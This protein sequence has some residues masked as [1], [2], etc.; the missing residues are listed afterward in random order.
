MVPLIPGTLIIFISLVSPREGV[1]CSFHSNFGYMMAG[2]NF[3]PMLKPTGVV[4]QGAYDPMAFFP[5]CASMFIFSGRSKERQYWI[6][7]FRFQR[8]L[9]LHFLNRQGLVSY[10]TALEILRR[11]VPLLY[12]PPKACLIYYLYW[13]YGISL[14]PS[15][16]QSN[17]SHDVQFRI[18]IISASKYPRAY[19]SHSSD[20]S[21]C[22]PETGGILHRPPQGV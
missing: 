11:R 2:E 20:M 16:V 3:I 15:I 22:R 18:H 4:D 13:R 17:Y 5:V 12:T 6:H 19:I 9:L 1:F 14:I 10:E 7:C 21:T 8:E